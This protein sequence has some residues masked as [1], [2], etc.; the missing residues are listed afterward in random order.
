LSLFAAVE[1]AQEAL[2]RNVSPK[3]IADWVA[4]QI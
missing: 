3:V 2:D 4:L 1:R